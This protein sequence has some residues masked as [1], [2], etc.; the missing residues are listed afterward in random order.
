MGDSG[1]PAVE[2]PGTKRHVERGQWAKSG[3]RNINEKRRTDAIFT[4][5]IHIGICDDFVLYVYRVAEPLGLMVSL[6]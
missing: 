2:S 1:P 3:S 5:H 6:A 4:F